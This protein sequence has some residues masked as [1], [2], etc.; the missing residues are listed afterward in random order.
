MQII[1]QH[2][3]PD[4]LLRFIAYRCDDGDIC[5]GFEGHGLAWHTHASILA[6][7]SGLP[8]DAAVKKYI[9]DL[10]N[11]RSIIEIT[12][13]NGEIRFVAIVDGPHDDPYKQAD[14][15]VELRYWDGSPVTQ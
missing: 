1:E 7:L 2:V 5:L 15:R 12:R 8:D 14:E 6:E 9:G 3:S 11:G 4:G 10:I 13:V